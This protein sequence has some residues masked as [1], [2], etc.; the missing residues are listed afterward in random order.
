MM[1]EVMNAIIQARMDSTRLPGKV[2]MDMEGVPILEHII[3]RLNAVSAINTVIVATSDDPHDDAIEAFC[4]E[5]SLPCVRGSEDN[6]L[7]RFGKAA[8]LYPAD[9]YIRATGDNPMIDIGL[10]EEMILFFKN[11]GL[12]Y[13]YCKNYPIGIG[14]EIF[15][16]QALT[17]ALEQANTPY[18]LEHVTPYM[19]QRMPG[20]KVEFYVSNVD[21]SKMRLTIDTESDFIFAKEIFHRLY[22]DKPF[23]DL[24]DI[25][26]VLSK[27]PE[28]RLINA[29]IR[30]KTF[31]HELPSREQEA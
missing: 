12:T 4:Q 25:R 17:D 9:V 27:E 30:Q 7:S 2:L 24:A 6:V 18:E 10:I 20:R 29:D 8:E 21:E 26:K 23:F 15:T 22:K 3:R 16:G 14:V 11:R 5:R 28:L 31:V 13:T 19:Y 1:E